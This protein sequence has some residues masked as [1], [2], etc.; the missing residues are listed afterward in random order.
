LNDNGQSGITLLGGAGNDTYIASN[1]G[2]LIT[3]LANNGTDTIQTT[4]SSYQLPADIERLLYTGNE[5]FTSTATA[6]GERI[7]GATG[8]DLLAD[9]GFANVALRG[10]GGADAFTVTSTSTTVTEV[11]GSTGSTVMTSLASYAL[12]ANVQN[13]TYTGTGNLTG[14]GNGLANT[15]TGGFGN[16]TLSA[17]GG[18]DTLIGGAGNDTLAGGGGADTFV[19]APVNP[20]ITNGVYHA[21]F[22][23]DVI[24]DFTASITNANHDVLSFASSMF[25]A[26][27]TA[28]TLLGGAALN[29]AGGLV[30][31]AQSGSSVVITIDPTDTITLNNVTLSVL[32]TA[33]AADVHFV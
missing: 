8:A 33:A 9:G 13:L 18:T 2:T 17:N 3:E 22:G 23:T 29:A 20:T 15:L 6:A 11:A 30:T 21:G 1:P 32:K 26:G 12:P 27:T 5:S 10:G 16:D 24:T 4:L 7:T 19:F 31:V 14:T 25:D 28:S